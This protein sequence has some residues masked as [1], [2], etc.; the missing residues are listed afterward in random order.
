MGV[1]LLRRVSDV[2]ASPRDQRLGSRGHGK[3]PLRRVAVRPARR[4][5]RLPRS[6]H[7]DVREPRPVHREIWPRDRPRVVRVQGPGWKGPRPPT[8]VHGLDPPVLR[9]GSPKPAE[10]REG[11]RFGQR[12]PLRGATERSVSRV[13]PGQCGDHRRRAAALRRGGPRPRDRDDAG[14]RAQAG[15]GADREH[16][17]PSGLPSVRNRG[18]SGRLTFPRQEELRDVGRG[19]R[20]VGS[21]G[22]VGAPAAAHRAVR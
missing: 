9:L 1:H 18:S 14:D 16:R 6:R 15:E 17:D 3:A 19:A 11:L 21:A 13:L 2:R 5:V 10:A 22:F 4:I 8:R 7:P 20:A 12:V